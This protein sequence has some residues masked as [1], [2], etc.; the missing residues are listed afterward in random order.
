MRRILLAALAFLPGAALAHVSYS[1]RDYLA[2]GSFDGLSTY[3]ITGQR[4]TGNYGWA[5]AADADWGDSHRGRFLRF[6][7]PEASNVTIKAWA[8]SGVAFTS[9]GQNLVALGDLAPGFSVY[10]GLAPPAAHEGGDHPTYLANHAGFLPGTPYFSPSRQGTLEG[11]WNAVGVWWISNTL[12]EKPAGQPDSWWTSAK[13]VYVGHALDGNGI[14]VTGDSVVDFA[15]DG[16]ADGNV[17]KTFT[18]GPGTYSVVIGG[19][20][21]AGQADIGQRGFSTSLTL[22][23]VPEPETWALMAG[24]LLML[25]A[26][27]RSRRT[28]RPASRS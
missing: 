24:G 13:L 22:A 2:N 7:L 9:G 20:D 4:V 26:V 16:S 27:A 15:G 14:D 6:T 19:L 11:S 10:E 17:S 23:P 1:G 12:A 21:Y 18:L 25:S 3:T 28:V 5:D 8:Q